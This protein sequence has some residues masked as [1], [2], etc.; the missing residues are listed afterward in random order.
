MA[1]KNSE[2]TKETLKLGA[3]DVVRELQEEARQGY[4]LES[5]LASL[6][7]KNDELSKELEAMKAT[8]AARAQEESLVKA[9]REKAKEL[10]VPD[11][12]VTETAIRRAIPFL[13][14]VEE[15]NQASEI[16]TLVKEWKDT[17]SETKS[18]NLGEGQR[19]D[20]S[21]EPAQEGNEEGAQEAEKPK[22]YIPEDDKKGAVAALQNNIY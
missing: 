1:D 2:V 14:S 6:Q 12:K 4:V 8:E 22:G 17:P 13:K 9:L 11:A 16:E 15:A 18:K 19:P 5:E 3:P 10:E 20:E 21:G 7:E